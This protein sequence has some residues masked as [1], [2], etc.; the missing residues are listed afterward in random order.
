VSRP[1]EA[2]ASPTFGCRNFKASYKGIEAGFQKN[3]R[4]SRGL[5]FF[6]S[7]TQPLFPGS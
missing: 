7:D 6:R 4:S 3:V 1:V 5:A 2:D